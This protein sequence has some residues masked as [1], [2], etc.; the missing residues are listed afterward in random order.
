M[1]IRGLVS[2]SILAASVSVVALGGTGCGSTKGG[3]GFD[4]PPATG[5]GTGD[6]DASVTPNGGTDNTDPGGGLG[7][8]S[9]SGGTQLADASCATA[10]ATAT[11]QPVYMSFVL[12]GSGSMLDDNKWTAV[13]AAL[14]SI[15]DDF[16]TKAD[17]SF[18]AGL[19]TFSDKKDTTCGSLFGGCTGPYPTAVD[20]P[21]AF[22]DATQHSKLRARIDSSNAK[23]D[24]P[25]Q[26]ALTGAYAAFEAF[27]PSG[28]LATGGKKVLV[29]LTD[30]VPTD[31]SQATLTAA[32][33]RELNLAGP[34]GPITTFVIGVGKF[35]ST[36]TQSFDPALLGALAK[37][38][39]AA[40]A[41]CNVNETQDVTKVCYFEVD[42]SSS[43]SSQLTQQFVDAINKIRGQVASC[44]FQLKAGDAGALDPKKVNV[45]LKSST[46]VETTISQDPT[47]GWTYD[48]PS[49][50][51]KV[52]L[53]GSSCTR[54]TSEA[55]ISMQIVLGCATKIPQ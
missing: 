15:F 33:T 53:H 4:D 44:E 8:V 23:G 37:A 38:G 12:D 32:A 27:T 11:R 46:G 47:N 40:P 54:M 36:S 21:I 35:P 52:V 20:V 22:V 26:A 48:N 28:Q 2:A 41:G 45:V 34:K 42:P 24:T 50:P 1:K 19:I 5:T 43:S 29:I 31:G 25:T 9:D 18:G 17:P 30:G 7:N 55:N 3:S 16:K 51:T 39:G 6:V 49:N 14:D 13:V 10:T